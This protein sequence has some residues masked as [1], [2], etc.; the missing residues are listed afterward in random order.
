MAYVIVPDEVVRTDAKRRSNH[1]ATD[2]RQQAGLDQVAA[3]LRESRRDVLRLRPKLDAEFWTDPH[4]LR[5]LV[6][7]LLENSETVAE[8]HRVVGEMLAKPWKW[9]AEYAVARCYAL[10]AKEGK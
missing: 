10:D 3:F 4:K 2:I 5:H 1:M 7:Y 9:R 8:A 6:L